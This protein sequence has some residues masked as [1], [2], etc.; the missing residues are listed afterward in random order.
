M[1]LR[2]VPHSRNA[3]RAAFTLLEVLIVVAILVVLAGVGGVTYMKFLEEAKEDTAFSQIKNLE[4][5]AQSVQ[6]RQ[7]NFPQT[8]A[9]LTQPS[10]DGGQPALEAEAIRDPWG[11][12]YAYDAAGGHNG[13]RKPDISTTTP[14]GKVI[15]NWPGGR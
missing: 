9:E 1:I 3:A 14:T 12:E 8:L 6:I 10:A 7:G 4:K 2:S 5:V 13:G 15:G 11:K